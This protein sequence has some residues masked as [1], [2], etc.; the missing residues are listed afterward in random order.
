MKRGI[1]PSAGDK[2]CAFCSICEENCDHLFFSCSVSSEVWYNVFK[3]VGFHTV[4]HMKAENN[5]IQ[6]D[7]INDGKIRKNLRFLIWGATVWVIWIH[8]N[9]IIFQK[10][11]IDKVAM[12]AHIKFISWSWFIMRKE[13]ITE[14]SFDDWLK[15]PLKCLQS[16]S[17]H[18]KS[19]K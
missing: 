3:W 2:G 8:R 12:I 6:F 7:F 15:E 19:G 13:N 14:S 1:I 18:C 11:K 4:M 16:A 10:E 5:L 9:N 17:S